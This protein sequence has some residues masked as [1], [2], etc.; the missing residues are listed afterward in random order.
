MYILKVLIL[1]R[2]NPFVTRRY[3]SPL[4]PVLSPQ[5]IGK[6]KI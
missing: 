6:I 3:L 5:K 4:V 1:I 2:I